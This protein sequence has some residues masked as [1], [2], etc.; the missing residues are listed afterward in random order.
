MKEESRAV[1]K[2]VWKWYKVT[3][4]DN[5][6]SINNRYRNKSVS[7]VCSD[8]SY[9]EIQNHYYSNQKRSCS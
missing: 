1:F 8:N 6:L 9:H 5:K 3:V 2:T 4:I 7:I